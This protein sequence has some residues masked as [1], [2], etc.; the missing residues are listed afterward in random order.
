[1]PALP[2]VQLY[3]LK[4]VVPGQYPQFWSGLHNLNAFGKNA[5]IRWSRPASMPG[6]RQSPETINICDAKLLHKCILQ[7]GLTTFIEHTVHVYIHTCTFIHVV[8]KN[9]YSIK[10]NLIT[11]LLTFVHLLFAT[12]TSVQDCLV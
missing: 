2:S 9:K 3:E 12:F 4:S 6:S 5:E 7:F 8:Q 10:L 1:M 11:V